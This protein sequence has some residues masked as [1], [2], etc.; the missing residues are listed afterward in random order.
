MRQKTLVVLLSLVFVNVR[1]L[2]AAPS[3]TPST[4][5]MAANVARLA[6]PTV[7]PSTVLLSSFKAEPL[8]ANPLLSQVMIDVVSDVV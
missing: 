2:S 8:N 1:A 3:A 7:R 6:K 5:S 4:R